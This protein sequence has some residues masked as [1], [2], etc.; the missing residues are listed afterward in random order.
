MALL[1]FS[2]LDEVVLVLSEL[3]PDLSCL[4]VPLELEEA[5][6]DLVLNNYAVCWIIFTI[7]MLLGFLEGFQG[8]SKF[9]F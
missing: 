7:L 3:V 2:F 9:R 5:F 4:L 8:F 6:P 1:S